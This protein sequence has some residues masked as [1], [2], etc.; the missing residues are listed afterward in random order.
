MSISIFNFS[1]MAIGSVNS[2]LDRF[3]IIIIICL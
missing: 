2:L 3:S 1:I